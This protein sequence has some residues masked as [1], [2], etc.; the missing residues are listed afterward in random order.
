MARQLS[1]DG[2]QVWLLARDA[3]RLQA[4]LAQVNAARLAAT[5]HCGALSCDVSD[6]QQVSDA[7][8]QATD[9]V[10]LPD[11]L[12]NSAGIA[13]PGYFEKLPLELFRQEM[14]VNY[15]GAVHT[16]HALAPGMIARGSGQIINMS[17][18]GGFLGVFG[19]T[20]YSAS[21]YALTG[22]TDALRSELKP[23]GIRTSIVFPPDAD[24]PMLR[25]EI[26][27]RPPESQAIADNLHPASA[28]DVA[29]KTLREAAR[30]AYM[31]FPGGNT[32]FWYWA[33][34]L[35]GGL[36][37]SIVDAIIADAQKKMKKAS[38]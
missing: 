12:I 34:S 8:R 27:L 23:H 2:A 18:A 9:R 24:T 16:C 10:G 32:L 26:P 5:Q 28:E 19:Y 4:A 14:A 1:A 36:R 33:V 15:F 7:L 25:R 22:F 11:V 20:A 21:K 17:S 30:G 29:R 6:A 3:A 38:V 35:L 13:T 37:Y 31:I